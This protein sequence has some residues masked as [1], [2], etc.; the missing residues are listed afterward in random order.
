MISTRL[1][2][3]ES[4]FVVTG[5]RSANPVTRWNRHAPNPFALHDAAGGLGPLGGGFPDPV[6]RAGPPGSAATCPCTAISFPTPVKRPS[7][8]P[9]SSVS[10][11]VGPFASS[12][13]G[14]ALTVEEFDD[15]AL[16]GDPRRQR[17]ATEAPSPCFRH[18]WPASSFSSSARMAS[19]LAPAVLVRLRFIASPDADHAPRR[20]LLGW[21]PGLRPGA[22]LR[23]CL[24]G[25][26][27]V[28]PEGTVA[29][30][31]DLVHGTVGLEEI[32][33]PL[34]LLLVGRAKKPHQ[35][36]EGHHRRHEIGPRP[37][38]GPAMVTASDDHPSCA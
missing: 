20:R 22:V 30:A 26:H 24:F 15:Q 27:A 10:V 12:K 21:L 33:D 35:Q 16:V 11:S 1:F 32:R 37:F 2:R 7:R 4:G 31:R 8:S 14:V 29:T 36:K 9:R 5:R 34:A 25:E 3:P 19:S 17:D 6:L 23:E 18:R 38:P 28:A 13:R